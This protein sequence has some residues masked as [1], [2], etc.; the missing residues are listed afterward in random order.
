[1]KT[2]GTRTFGFIRA[3]ARVV[4][5]LAAATSAT[6]AMA[7]DSL[8][9]FG[10]IVVGTGSDVAYGSFFVAVKKGFFQKNGIDDN[11]ALLERLNRELA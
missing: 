1:M 10:K 9:S 4:A 2:S 6:N 3:A 7:A 11:W 8:K 5:L